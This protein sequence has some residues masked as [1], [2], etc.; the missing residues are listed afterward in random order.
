MLAKKTSWNKVAG[1]YD[2]YLKQP[3]NFHKEIIVPGVL[4]MLALRP[5]E[6]LLDVACGQGLFASEAVKTGAKVMGLDASPDLI[7]KARTRVA[8]GRFMVGDAKKMVGVADRACDAA[9]IILGVQNIEPLPPVFHGLSRVL[10]IDGR[11]VLVLTH[12]AFRAPR[13]SGWGW[14]DER[15]L[16]YRRMDSYMTEQK[17]PIVMH[18]GHEVSEKTWTFHRPLSAYVKW[19]VEAGFVVA[20]LEEW[21]SNKVSTLGYK[22]AAENR[23]RVEFPLFLAIKILKLT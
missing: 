9:V 11:A 1:W 10:K 7:A 17:V 14:D 21:S 15:K 16:Q 8:A 18:P 4:R 19:L 12:P 22:A 23:A 2:D 3:S 20:G 6:V 13:Q 5:S